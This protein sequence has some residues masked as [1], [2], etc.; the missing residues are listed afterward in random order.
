[1]I[2]DGDHPL[3]DAVNKEADAG[4]GRYT[5]ML[6]GPGGNIDHVVKLITDDIIDRIRPMIE[7][8]VRSQYAKMLRS[9]PGDP[10]QRARMAHPA[11]SARP[12]RPTDD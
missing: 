5:V 9:I 7:V 6:S 2:F 12:A 11:A 8:A 3:I 1:M 4:F 10:E